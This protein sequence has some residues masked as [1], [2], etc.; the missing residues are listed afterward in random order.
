M[1]QNGKIKPQGCTYEKIYNK[2]LLGINS[3]DAQHNH[4]IAATKLAQVGLPSNQGHKDP[5][6]T[7]LTC[8]IILHTADFLDLDDPKSVEDAQATYAALLWRYT[9]LYR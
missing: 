5:V 9:V 7:T 6:V 8:G 4:R 3:E 2:K 1:S